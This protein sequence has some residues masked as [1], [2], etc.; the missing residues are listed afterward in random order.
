MSTHPPNDA[1]AHV[2]S[3]FPVPATVPVAM[4]R[5]GVPTDALKST[6]LWVPEAYKRFED[7][8]LPNSC[9][10]YTFPRGQLSGRV[11]EA[12]GYLDRGCI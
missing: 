8:V 12:G 3:V 6:P 9:V 1:P 11:P 5:T 10:I 7:A 2:S 4:A